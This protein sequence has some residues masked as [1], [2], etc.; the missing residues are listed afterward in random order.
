MRYSILSFL[1]AWILPTKSD[2]EQ[3]RDLC[4]DIDSRRKPYIIQKRYNKKIQQLRAKNKIKVVFI[5]CTNTKWTYE[6]LLQE[7]KNDKRFEIEVLI[8]TYIDYT[9][10][11]WQYSRW[12][13]D[14]NDNYAWF[15]KKNISVKYLYSIEKQ[16]FIDLKSFNPDIVFYEQPW[17]LPKKYQPY[18]VSKYALTFYSNYGG[19]NTTK[20]SFKTTKSF[21]Q[22]LFCYLVDNNF[23]KQQL[24]DNF[25]NTNNVYICGNL[26]LDIYNE[27]I[28]Y[29]KQIWKTSNKKRV[30]WAPHFSFVGQKLLNIGTFDKNY[31]Y[32]YE[33]AQK[34]NEIEFILKPHPELK[35][36]VI[37][38][39][40]MTEDEYN[41]YMRKWSLLDNAQIYDKGGYFDMFK[42]SDALITD[43]SSFLYEYLPSERPIIHLTKYDATP[44]NEFGNFL[45][46]AYYKAYSI[47]ELEKY[48]KE[49]VENDN[50][51]LK[52]KRME[53]LQSLFS[54][55]NSK[56]ASKVKN[57]ILEITF[58]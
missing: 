5:S 51:Y 44:F 4:K 53:V 35:R 34:H 45:T 23:A 7:L 49:V 47:Q 18:N 10:G 6:S 28:D 12:Q 24:E 21:R 52:E 27:P 20:C 15:E 46:S 30:I 33:Y 32:L 41:S 2:R 1:F 39:N 56:A 22:D 55:N 58:K 19:I 42:T 9:N 57:Y 29:N 31:Q 54:K 13:T 26:K 17:Q 50:D 16:K 8:N 38:N 40:F 48:L 11:K 36:H 37:A 14:M 3:F 43:C 25:E